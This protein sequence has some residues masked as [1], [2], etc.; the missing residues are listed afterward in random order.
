MEFEKV[1][2]E[3]SSPRGMISQIYQLLITDL[4]PFRPQHAYMRK[5]EQALGEELPL[6]TWQ[7]IWSQVAKSYSCTQ[8]KQYKVLYNWYQTPDLHHS[9][10]P[11]RYIYWSCPLIIIFWHMVHSL[12]H[13]I[14][15][16]WVPFNPKIFWVSLL[17][18][19]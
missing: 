5:W 10:Y 19:V 12:L 1:C 3:G 18:I 17:Q 2:L 14:L 7:L 9:I 8:R 4:S 13:S 11:V 15:G 16:S 6:K